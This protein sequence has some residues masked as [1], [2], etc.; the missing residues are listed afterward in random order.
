MLLDDVKTIEVQQWLRKLNYAP[1]T[2][3]KLRNLM[4]A[5]FVHCKRWELYQ[6]DNP[7]TL[8]RQG[9]KRLHEPETLDINKIPAIL[10]N[11]KPDAIRVMAAVAGGS[12]RRRS[13]RCPASF[14]CHRF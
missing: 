9:T 14:S 12:P 10:S 7:I 1:G 13:G 11:I 2:K 3:A 5:L 6:E 4:S 8:V